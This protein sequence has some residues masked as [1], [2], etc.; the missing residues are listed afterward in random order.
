MLRS[1]INAC[2]EHAKEL[3]ASI[4]FKLPEWAHYSPAQWEAEPDLAKWCRNHQKQRPNNRKS[5]VLF[6]KSYTPH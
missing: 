2:I 1:E 5:F 4:A 3:Y 6:P